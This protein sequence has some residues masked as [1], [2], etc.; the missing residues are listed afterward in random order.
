MLTSVM[1]RLMRN[2]DSVHIIKLHRYVVTFT[3]TNSL[4]SGNKSGLIVHP[5]AYAYPA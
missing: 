3:I 5:G 4:E 1:A 2:A